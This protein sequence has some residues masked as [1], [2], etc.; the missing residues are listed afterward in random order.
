M[1]YLIVQVQKLVV[2]N[3]GQL[4]ATAMTVLGA[5]TS[6]VLNGAVMMVPVVMKI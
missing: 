4:I 5:I 3:T 1:K 6:T 2:M